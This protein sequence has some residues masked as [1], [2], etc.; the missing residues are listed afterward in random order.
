MHK[1]SRSIHIIGHCEAS[2][3]YS[4][5]RNHLHTCH[6][7]RSFLVTPSR[8]LCKVTAL[9]VPQFIRNGDGKVPSGHLPLPLLSANMSSPRVRPTISYRSAPPSMLPR[10]SVHLL[11][12]PLLCLSETVNM[13]SSCISPSH[14]ASLRSLHRCPLVPLVHL[15]PP[16]L[17]LPICPV[18]V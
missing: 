17:C 3:T 16:L 2:S 6:R 7:L 11:P 1:D 18:L 4:F 15:L 8:R 13:F 12:F 5:D 10:P 14:T 9:R